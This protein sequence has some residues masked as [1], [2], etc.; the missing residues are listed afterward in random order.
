MSGQKPKILTPQQYQIVN[1]VVDQY[2]DCNQLPVCINTSETGTGK[3]Y[4]TVSIAA[5]LGCSVFILA[6]KTVMHSWQ[7]ECNDAGVPI[8]YLSNY[9]SFIRKQNPYMHK[10][11][12]PSTEKTQKTDI[13]E[14]TQ[15]TDIPEKTQK[16]EKT[17]KTKK[18]KKNEKTEKNEKTKKNEKTEKNEKPARL[19]PAAL[20]KIQNQAETPETPETPPPQLKKFKYATTPLLSN[21]VATTKVMFVFDEF[22]ALKTEKSTINN[23][24][25]AMNY[26]LLRRNVCEDSHRSLFMFLSATPYD[27]YDNAFALYRV[28]GMTS[29]RSSALYSTDETKMKKNQMKKIQSIENNLITLMVASGKSVFEEEAKCLIY[30]IRQEHLY[31]PKSSTNGNKYQIYIHHLLNNLFFSMLKVA[32]PPQT[33]QST[34]RNILFD[35]NPTICQKIGLLLNN[36]CVIN[37]RRSKKKIQ[38]ETESDEEGESDDLV[39]T[40]GGGGGGGGGISGFGELILNMHAIERYRAIFVREYALRLLSQSENSKLCIFVNFIDVLEYL[41]TELA[42]YRPL[43]MKGD[44][45]T[46]MRTSIMNAFNQPN[47]EY[48]V[49]ILMASVGGVGI[50]LHDTDGRFPRHSVIFPDYNLKVQCCG[51]TNRIGCKS[52]TCIDFCYF[53][54]PSSSTIIESRIYNII[55]QK[56][57]VLRD[58]IHDE[59]KDIPSITEKYPTNLITVDNLTDEFIEESYDRIERIHIQNKKNK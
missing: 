57:S 33:Y 18:T 34:F 13:P 28:F 58:V 48:R 27:K 11:L 25:C 2:N 46:E 16:T 51:R 44:F 31:H 20:K 24:V 37:E 17:E 10:V 12:I 40:R 14:K 23:I 7:Q 39:V 4:T 21:L 5:K 6:P 9:S 45:S 3:T 52:A 1:N 49:I 55:N 53:K 41:Q 36:M 26:W 22:Q 32:M 19:K 15:K 29:L 47:T 38:R 30:D 54:M 35:V 43:V 8:V 56:K 59:L 42:A 50:N